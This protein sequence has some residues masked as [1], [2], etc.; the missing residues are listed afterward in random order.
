MKK[1]LGLRESMLILF[2]IF[3][4]ALIQ[5]IFPI[6][7]RNVTRMEE[8]LIS[9]RLVADIHYIEDLI[10]DGDW[11]LKGDYICRGDVKVGDGTQEHANLE[12]FLLHEEKTGTFSYVFIRCGDE[13]L[14]Y[15]EST[16]TQVGYQ[17]GHFL[18]VAGST[19]DP[20]GNSIVGTYMDKQVA[21]ILD[22]EDTY[23]GEANV[24]GGMIY[25][26][27]DTLK[28]K[29]GNVIG[30]IV[31]GRGISELRAQI[32][33][34]TRT[35][36]ISGAAFI[37]LGILILFLIMNRWVGGLRKATSFLRQIEGGDIPKERMSER[38]PEEI[39][40]MMQG[41]NSLADTLHENDELRIKSETDQLTGL[42]NR[43]GLNHKGGEIIDASIEKKEPVS[44]GFLD[45]D[46]FKLYN[47]NYGHQAGDDCIL[48]VANVLRTMQQEGKIFAARYGGDEFIVV[49]HG[50]DRDEVA[51]I[52][53]EIRTEVSSSA[54]P[55]AYSENASIVTVSQGHCVGIPEKGQSLSDFLL[56]ADHVM[57]EVKNGSKDG[58]RIRTIEEEDSPDRSDEDM[59]EWSTYHDRLTQLLNREGFYRETSRILQE[60]PEEKYNIVRSNIKNFKLVNQLFGYE[61]GNEVLA[62]T[63]EMLKSGRLGAEV[64][65]RIHGDHFAFL[66]KRENFDEGAVRECFHQLSRKIEDS[67]YVLQYCVGVYEVRDPAEDVFVMCDHANIAI[68]SIRQESDIIVAYYNDNMMKHILREN[69]VIAEFDP[70]LKAGQFRIFLQ[71][72]VKA[73]GELTGA[74]ALVRWFRENGEMVP[75][76]DFIGILEESGL[77]YKLDLFV[78][79][80]AAKTL[81]N[82]K[83]TPLEKLSVSVNISPRDII[84]VDIEKEFEKLVKRYDIP[85]SKLNLEF[86]ETTLMSDVERYIDLV[87][88][89]REKG[90]HVEVDDFGS[91]YS[92]LNMLKDIRADV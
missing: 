57:Y 84:Y 9:S 35:A 40:A 42:A 16:P 39:S 50:K 2:T 43:F 79:E 33:R 62:D 77:I 41:I 1:T 8:D 86:T 61:K 26:R 32:N 47:D 68:S 10:G 54:I 49:T 58:Y 73:D 17:E 51:K 45:I 18:R 78:W 85:R 52:A 7:N 59:I 63:A 24:A 64:I 55:R 70:A 27:Y 74:E 5:I 90:F 65:G 92:S 20:N 38:G 19:R 34:T 29:D 14:G 72:I 3:G 22:A 69:E 6:L 81:N 71:P 88:S 75:P 91:G 56:R 66:V 4:V 89:L 82:W 76:G 36:V 21:D 44:V 67:E 53:E 46:Y 28:D 23:D 25:C 31:V 15:V 48:Q 11:N 80:E 37:L 30:A 12:P 13:G 83:G 60:N 87:A